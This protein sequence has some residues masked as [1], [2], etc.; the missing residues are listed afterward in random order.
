M[1]SSQEPQPNANKRRSLKIAAVVA[2]IVATGIAYA[3]LRDPLFSDAYSARK[4]PG[5]DAWFQEAGGKS[6]EPA[7]YSVDDFRDCGLTNVRGEMRFTLPNQARF[8]GKEE[9]VSSIER[10]SHGGSGR[11]G[12]GRL[13]ARYVCVGYDLEYRGAHGTKLVPE[14]YGID[15]RKITPADF[16][17]IREGEAPRVVFAGPYGPVLIVGVGATDVA[18]FK[19]MKVGLFDARTKWSLMRAGYGTMRVN[20]DLVEV[21]VMLSRFHT[22]PVELFLDVEFGNAEMARIAPKSLTRAKAGGVDVLVLGAVD[23][24]R[25]GAHG[26]S[27]VEEGRHWARLIEDDAAS[28][29]IVMADGVVEFSFAMKD[30]AEVAAHI[31][32]RTGEIHVLQASARLDQIEHIL[33]KPYSGVKRFILELDRLPGQAH[34]DDSVRDLADRRNPYARFHDARGMLEMM[35]A[36]MDVDLSRSTPPRLNAVPGA[37]PMTLTNTT[38]REIA[39]L[40]LKSTTN[41]NSVRLDRGSNR[42]ILKRPLK[43]VVREKIDK[44]MN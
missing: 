30:G 20:S 24:H 29:F 9:A 34:V 38:P 16:D 32:I 43:D 22:G 8:P 10:I 36:N 33:A 40:F 11:A 4:N 15:G 13:Q 27:T 19:I 35:C 31:P 26:S 23:G 39:A 21:E 41:Y 17:D 7:G 1:E 2:A 3:V 28:T 5:Y 44:L 12:K 25:Y 14:A 18:R 6:A 37:F 42:L